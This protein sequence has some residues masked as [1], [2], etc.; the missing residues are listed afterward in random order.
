MGNKLNCRVL[1]S[2]VHIKQ[3]ITHDIYHITKRG[4]FVPYKQSNPATLFYGRL[5]Q[6]RKVGGRVFV[7]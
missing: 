5:Y 6:A 3:D 7:C 1:F 4:R 2:T